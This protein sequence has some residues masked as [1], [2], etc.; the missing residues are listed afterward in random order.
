VIKSLDVRN[1]RIADM[2]G[3]EAFVN[4]EYLDCSS[5]HLTGLDISN[6]AG[7][8]YLMCDGNQLTNLEV[9]G[10]APLVDLSCGNN[11]LDSLDISHNLV[12]QSVSLSDMPSLNK[13][14]V[15]EMPFPLDGVKVYTTD[16][17]NIY[18]TADCD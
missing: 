11:L 15:W 3:I 17:P 12:L 5:N 8:L 18:F 2:A 7:L 6:N 10:N 9:S 1:S 4:L 16:S 13:V 14:C